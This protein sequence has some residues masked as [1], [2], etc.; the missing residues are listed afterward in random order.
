MLWLPRHYPY[1]WKYLRPFWPA[2][3]GLSVILFSQ[4]L[5]NVAFPFPAK[6]ILNK[7]IQGTSETT[8]KV[9]FFGV[10]FGTHGAIDALYVASGLAITL[11]ALLLIAAV[12][13]QMTTTSIVFR[14]RE[15]MRRDLFQRFFSRKQSYL[16]GQKKVNLMGR[17]SGDVE[18]LEM[19]I[20][21][22]IPAVARDIP[23]MITMIAMMFVVNVRMATIFCVAMPFFVT[24]AYWFTLR[25]RDASKQ[26][27]R[28]TVKFEEE[29]HEALSSMAVVKSL[30]GEDKL[31]VRLLDRVNGLTRAGQRE[32]NA[33]VGLDVTIM[34]TQH[35]VKF[36][37]ILLGSIGI[38]RGELGLGDVFQFL[39]YLDILARHV[40]AFTKF[41]SKYP[42]LVA[43][44]E[45]IRELDSALE[46]QPEESGP[47]SLTAADVKDAAVPIALRNLTF[48]YE[49]GR[50]IFDR[51][52][53]EF[54]R[55]ALIAVVGPSGAG[56]SS[57]SRLLNR[58]QDPLEG[59]V[60]V[61]GRPARDYRL[62]DLRT[63]VRV[64]SQENFLLAGTIRENLHLAAE[65][66][67]SD[68]EIQAALAQVNATEFVDAMPERLDTVIG[69][70]GQ[71][72][73][74][75]QAKRLHLARAFLEHPSEVLL[76]D[77]PSSGL[78]T[79]SADRVM[80]SLQQLARKKS[81]VFWVT[82]RMSEAPLADKILFF[83]GTGNPVL[84]THAELL[85]NQPAYAALVASQDESRSRPAREVSVVVVDKN[86][87]EMAPLPAPF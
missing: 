55:G 69:E 14:F 80:G 71:Q 68:T 70:G 38:L 30:R 18:N 79:L 2:F 87:G 57:F 9:E 52:D 39:A 56:K 64:L 26:L 61:A 20:Q 12:I 29:T 82:H 10:N 48:R 4:I 54:P 63:E 44:M 24:A 11:S 60:E 35:L 17:V 49:E 81:V 53:L 58:L 84:S 42:K 5:L 78:D 47:R 6:F 62:A 8:H 3:L 19:L 75:G 50:L 74:G 67:P 1:I 43:S 15:R 16:D 73:S 45:R 86:E 23:I 77:E 7:V 59:Y 21:S 41:L 83:P 72:V 76:F 31:F 85:R 51:Y 34:G 13:E 25:Y 37:F 28:R 22:G 27:R 32:R 66:T 46:K 65:G 40:N 33:A 36:G